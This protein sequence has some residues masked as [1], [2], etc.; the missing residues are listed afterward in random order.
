M[1]TRRL[2]DVSMDRRQF[3]KAS[4]VAGIGLTAGCSGGDG[5]AGDGPITIAGI[6]PESGPF[7]AWGNVH[8]QGVEFAI[9]EINNDGG[10]LDGRELEFIVEDTEGNPSEADSVFQRLVEQED[11]VAATGP[12]N[13]DVGVR[14]SQTAQSLEVPLFLHMSGTNAA[15]TTETMFTFRVG[16]LPAQ[17][18]IKSIAQL[19]EGRDVESAGAIIGDFAWGRSIETA[20]NEEFPIDVQIEAAPVGANDFTSQLRQFDSDLDMFLTTGHPP[21][22]LTITQQMFEVGLAPDLIPGSGY[23]ISLLVDALGDLTQEGVIT[24]H[25]N[26]IQTDAFMEVAER[27]G[28]E[29]GQY[30]GPN[31][32]Y[33]YVTAKLIAAGI[34][35]AGEADPIAIRD[36]MNEIQFETIYS[37][38]IEYQNNGELHNQINNFSNIVL[39]STDYAPDAN[40]HLEQFFQTDP[41]EAIPADLD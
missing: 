30:F 17:N 16:L 18:I 12:V 32:S 9:E 19:A 7:S 22:Q 2:F 28:E 13:S 38:P 1:Y 6:E 11:A 14:T 29:T 21:G 37:N 35:E 40:A 5:G 10:V 20:I 25:L 36:A 39:E 41:L 3:L 15:I 33:G 23:P 8:I 31:V 24:Y 26:D 4:G 34:E 27:F